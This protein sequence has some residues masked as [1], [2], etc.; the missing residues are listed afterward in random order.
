[1]NPHAHTAINAAMTEVGSDRAVIN[2]ERQ[3]IQEHVHHKI[4]STAPKSR[5]SI[6]LRKLFWASLPP[7]RVTSIWVPEANVL[8]IDSTS[9]RILS[10]TLTVDASR[11]RVIEMPT[12]GLPLRRLNRPVPRSCL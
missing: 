1:M 9:L 4:V 11:E 6:T 5:A 7:S 12:L 10:A 2:V 3:G 8:L